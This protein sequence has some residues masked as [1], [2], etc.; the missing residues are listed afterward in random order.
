MVS[1]AHY[2][3]ILTMIFGSIPFVTPETGT[4]LVEIESFRNA[5]DRSKSD[6]SIR[7]KAFPVLTVWHTVCRRFLCIVVRRSSYSMIL[8]TVTMLS[9]FYMMK[10]VMVA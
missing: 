1:V 3:C 2:I 5:R 7:R 6:C 9:A 4:L 10:T 8:R